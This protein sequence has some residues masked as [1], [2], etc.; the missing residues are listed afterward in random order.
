MRGDTRLGGSK[1]NSLQQETTIK[2]AG[3]KLSKQQSR[4]SCLPETYSSGGGSGSSSSSKTP[5]CPARENCGSPTTTAAPT[6]PS[7][8]PPAVAGDTTRPAE[9][10]P[11]VPMQHSQNSAESHPDSTSP[12][13]GNA[14]GGSDHEDGN[15][16]F[17]PP[18]PLPQHGNGTQLQRPGTG[19]AARPGVTTAPY[20]A[21]AAARNSVNGE[22]RQPRPP[23]RAMQNSKPPPVPSTLTPVQQS[24]SSSSSGSSS[25]RCESP[26]TA[27]T[28][29]TAAA[30]QAFCPPMLSKEPSGKT[31]QRPAAE[32]A[33]A[34]A[35]EAAAA[36]AEPLE[37]A[38]SSETAEP[39]EP[40]ETPESSRVPSLPSHIDVGEDDTPPPSWVPIGASRGPSSAGA[41]SAND[42]AAVETS[43]AATAASAA[44]LLAAWRSSI[45]FPAVHKT[46][47]GG[48]VSGYASWP[49]PLPAAA[50]TC[51]AVTPAVAVV[52]STMPSAAVEP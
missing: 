47:T 43:T 23:Q 1:T 41:K 21:A 40:S 51:A 37:P 20:A 36:A 2:V 34:E 5:S 16:L 4:K 46:G 52:P 13:R 22:E 38:E 17:P 30:A 42:T 26:P 18:L 6:P 31:L 25:G 11:A 10:L 14:G 19:A 7:P 27:A 9:A 12:F 44:H 33:A 48:G 49:S 35:A 8:P 39:A 24:P 45:N 29:A 50:T 28:A 15:Q 3:S 32:A